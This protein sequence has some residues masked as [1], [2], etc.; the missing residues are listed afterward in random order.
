MKILLINP[1]CFA[2][3][4]RDLYSAHLLGPFFTAQPNKRMTLGIPLALPTLAA[5]TAPEHSIQIIDEEIEQIDFDEPA[6]LVGI[7]AMTFKAKRAYEIARQFRKRRVPVVMGGIHATV[8]PGEVKQHVDSVVIGEAEDIWPRLLDDLSK[9]GRLEEFYRAEAF[10]DLH[11]SRS[12]RYDLVKNRNYIY[13]YLQTTR[14]CP[15][16]CEF[17]SVTTTSG[18]VVRKKSPEQV[19]A[20]VDA[21]LQLNPSRQFNVVDCISG[22][23]KRF[24]GTIAFIDD[25][26]A[27]DRDHA[28]AVCEAL[29]RYQEERGIAFIWYT[30]VNYIVGFDE[31]LLTAMENSNCQHLFIGFENLD[32]ETLKSMKKS[33]N[34][35][36]AYE[37]AIRN[38]CRHHMRVIFSTI[39]GD[40][41][42][43]QKSAHQLQSFIERNNI[44]HVLLNI[45]TPYPGTALAERMEREARLLTKEPQMYNIRNIVFKPNRISLLELQEIYLSLC[46]HLFNYDAVYRRGKNMLGITDRLYFSLIDRV[47]VLL[48][49]VL[50][51]VLLMLR[52]RVRW[53]IGLRMLFAAPR[54]LLY[55]GSLYALELLVACVD[56]DDFAAS[57]TVR[58]RRSD[59]GDVC[60]S[61]KLADLIELTMRQFPSRA[62][63]AKDYKGFYVPASLLAARGVEVPEENVGRPLLLLGGTSIPIVDRKELIISLL[64]AGYEVASIE[65]PI[66]CPLDFSSRPGLDRTLSLTSFLYH[67]QDEEAVKSVDIIAQSYSAF[68][69][70]R[71]L[72]GN[73]KFSALVPSITLINPPGLNE[74]ITFIKH[75]IRFV[76]RHLVTGYLKAFGTFFGFNDVPPKANHKVKRVYAR[77]EVLGIST[78]TF[79]TCLNL[80]RTFK[81]VHDIVTFRIKEPLRSLK[82][83]QGY[84]INVFLQSEDQV[85]PAQVSQEALKD[86]IP[87]DHVEVVPGGHNDLFF[88]KWQHPAFLDFFKRVRQRRILPC[89]KEQGSP[90]KGTPLKRPQ[91]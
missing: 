40:D 31:E 52:G 42:T 34:K 91:P 27:I 30:Q 9:R 10:P 7:T 12:P 60:P 85:V 16:N 26:F 11:K 68:E 49:F 20:E 45:L 35:P 50:T 22:K 69:T 41:N 44:L 14:G 19:I 57:E 89:N 80:V 66:G 8:C 36:E 84:E 4:G 82:N 58:L 71:S 65:N 78:W 51:C 13:S 39:I 46:I 37:E 73:P 67:L 21:L 55:H 76:V 56:Y 75:V 32:P 61:C 6:D 18:H 38:I 64:E 33:M 79:K 53:Q 90:I 63:R 83:D 47:K 3:S 77:R 29:R 2:E 86:L 17:C 48:G 59:Q 81:E 25:N 88:Q 24:V 62:D 5:H 1:S 72:A 43:S 70:I 28:R 23:K 74:N 15:Y 54:L 87:N